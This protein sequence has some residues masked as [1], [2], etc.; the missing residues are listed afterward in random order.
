MQAEII[1]IGDEITSGQLLDT[2]TQWL[3]R[4]LEELGIRVLYHSAVGDELEAC[5]EVL[6][7]ALARADVVIATGGLGPTADDLTRQ[8]IASAVGGELVLDPGALEQIRRLFARRKRQMPEQNRQQ[9]MV[10]AGGKMIPN[11]HGT[12]PGIEMEVARKGSIP[13]RLFA[14]PGVP[15]EMKQMWHESVAASL[16]AMG[17]GRRIIRRRQI[18]CFGAGE[19]Q[20]EAMLPDLIRRGRRPTVGINASQTT[21]ILRVAAEGATEQEC[22]AAIEPTVATIRRCLGRLVFGEDDDELQDAVVRLLR[23]QDRT[24]ST[25]EWG[26]AGLVADWLGGLAR[27]DGCYLG[28]VVVGAEQALRSVLG[29]GAELVKPSTPS[30]PAGGELARAMALGCRRRFASDYALAVGGLPE[31]DPEAADPKPVFVAL[32]APNG[33]QLESFPFAGHPATLRVFCAKWAL[34]MVRLALLEGS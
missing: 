30:T 25:A 9:A 19:S 17:A 2:N 1:A 29:V 12:A 22:R 10:P 32:A 6:R 3:S 34:N 33:V 28:G 24:L 21:I 26:T 20:I 8:A 4:R 5:A 14:L 27:A 13:G 18:K 31:F 15:A 16:R 7:R 11:P 23:R